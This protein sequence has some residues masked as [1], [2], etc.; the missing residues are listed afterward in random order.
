MFRLENLSWE[1]LVSAGVAAVV[2]VVVY[3]LTLHPLAGYPGPR[4][5]AATR[6]YEAYYDLFL[7]GQYVFK[8]Q[9]LHDK[10]GPI[11][12]ISPN[13]LHV[14]D[15]KF[16]DKLYNNEGKWNKHAWANDAFGVP[17]ATVVTVD[18]DWHKRRRAAISSYFSR[19]N[20]ASKQDILRRGAFKLCDRLNEYDGSDNTVNLSHAISAMARDVAG[21]FLLNR[22]YNN[23]DSPG[24]NA[25]MTLMS[26]GFGTVWRTCKHIPFLAQILKLLKPSFMVKITTDPGAKAFFGFVAGIL[27]V[28]KE[29]LNAGTDSGSESEKEQR[30]LI[31]HIVHSNLPAS[32]K[33]A[34]RINDELA[35]ISGAAFE[36]TANALRCMLYYVYGDA[37]ILDQLRE[38][39]RVLKKDKSITR[40]PEV[41]TSSLEQLPFL[42]A[43]L[44]ECLRL[45][46]GVVTRM[47]RV[48]PDRAI[49][50]KDYAIPAGTPVG[51]TPFLMHMD[52]N[53]FEDARAFKPERWMD[54][55]ARRKL[56]KTYAPFS[57]G[58]RI[59]LGMHFAWAELYMVT[60][61]LVDEYD[62]SLVGAGPKDIECVSDQF[63]VGVAD[64]SGI[65][66][67]VT[68]AV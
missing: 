49:I 37:N 39:I 3:R 8:I 38:E 19:P 26:Q 46:P 34:A 44:T 20:V 65:K 31:D 14:N 4:L 27:N 33:G 60:A 16:L 2:S 30:T 18:H 54:P 61:C 25:D 68:R 56:S 29:E 10:Y 59:C 12:R 24:F 58:T 13:E 64:P 41:E 9:E 66:A 15:A 57:K 11:I 62:F 35:S 28:I 21:E 36:T 52:E 6:L 55:E 32:E 47:A 45:A 17:N 53:V 48:A 67:R 22:Q 7:N 40:I 43:V 23:L 63:V 50:F 42:S 51:M 5:A 1:Y